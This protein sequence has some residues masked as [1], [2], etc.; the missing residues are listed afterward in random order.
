MFTSK[1][2]IQRQ[3]SS[4]ETHSS[5]G[6]HNREYQNKKIRELQRAQEEQ[7][8]K[9]AQYYLQQQQ[10]QQSQQAKIQQYLQQ[11]QAYKDQILA[12]YAQQQSHQLLSTN[13]YTEQQQTH[14][15]HQLKL[16]QQQLDQ[17]KLQQQQIEQDRVNKQSNIKHRLLYQKSL[18]QTNLP[19][20]IH[21][22]IQSLALQAASRMSLTNQNA[23]RILMQ[24]FIGHIVKSMSR[25]NQ[26]RLNRQIVQLFMNEV[27]LFLFDINENYKNPPPTTQP[28][29]I[30]PLLTPP[31]PPLLTTPIP[32]LLTTPIPSSIPPSIPQPSIPQP[33]I[34]QPSIPPLTTIQPPTRSDPVIVSRPD[35]LRQDPPRSD[36]VIVSRPDIL[37]QDPPRSEP[38][39]VS[40]PDILRPD[41]EPPHSVTQHHNNTEIEL[42]E[43]CEDAIDNNEECDETNV[44]YVIG[45]F[46]NLIIQLP[47]DFIQFKIL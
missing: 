27:Q 29:P 7:K 21:N 28:A 10:Y 38:V 16:Q 14:H 39:I 35:I 2:L 24:Q 36:P 8:Q 44:Y 13:R 11:Q 41:P 22:F 1:S 40:R 9:I 37:R 45:L 33:S 12:Y 46:E 19:Q 17:E 3:Y 30:P 6:H 32:P 34:P 5:S 20:N 4:R 47:E 42:Y 15:S 43:D 31:I 18:L 26:S 23:N 25:S